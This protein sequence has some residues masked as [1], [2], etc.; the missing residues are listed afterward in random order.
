MS[1]MLYTKLFPELHKILGLHGTVR[2]VFAVIFS[3]W[4]RS[5]R[6]V[7]VPGSVF[8]E[9][10]G[11]DRKSI[12]IAIAKLCE[13]GLILAA[14]APGKKTSYHVLVEQSFID[15]YIDTYCRR[16]GQEV[17]RHQYQGRNSTSSRDMTPTHQNNRNKEVINNKQLNINTCGM[18]I[19]E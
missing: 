14:K 3:F 13:R 17:N 15:D 2:D 1:R 10:L 16:E 5:R 6:P 7:S 9:I 4:F 18:Q 19:A 11:I 8:Q 12:Y